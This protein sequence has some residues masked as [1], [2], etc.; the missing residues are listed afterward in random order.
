M[1]AAGSAC[2]GQGRPRS[3]SA[4]TPAPAFRPEDALFL[5]AGEGGGSL[6]CTVPPGVQQLLV[7]P[8]P[9]CVFVPPSVGSKCWVGIRLVALRRLAAQLDL[10]ATAAAPP[11]RRRGTG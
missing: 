3:R 2:A 10:G 9:A 8:D 11:R 6:T 7:A 4:G 5:T 1:P